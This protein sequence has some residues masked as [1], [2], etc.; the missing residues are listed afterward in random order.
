[1]GNYFKTKPKDKL[2]REMIEFL[3]SRKLSHINEAIDVVNTKFP[4]SKYLEYSDYCDV[5]NPILEIWTQNVFQLL[6]SNSSLEG[7]N[8]IYESLAVFTIFSDEEQELKLQFIFQ[9]FD[10]DKSG[11][12]EK[13]E[14]VVALEKCIRGLCKLVHLPAPSIKDIDFYAERLFLELDRDYSYTISFNEFKLWIIGNFELQDFLLKY[15]LIQ[16]Y[17]NVTRRYKEK[18]ILYEN[19]FI[20]AVGN[21]KHD[22]CEL[23][24]IK[25]LFLTEFNNQQLEILELLFKT[26]Q[27]SS[28]AYLDKKHDG[29]ICKQA[30][31]DVMNAWA[32]FDA[33]DI[34]QDNE[35]SMSELKYLIYAY[36][37]DKPDYYRLQ[38]EMEI[39][40]M[41]QSGKIT[42]DEWIKYLCVNEKGKF[43]FRGTLQHQFNEYDKDHDGMLS[44]KDIKDLLKNSMKDLRTSFKKLNSTLNF[45]DMVDDLIEDIAKSLQ[46][47]NQDQHSYQN[48]MLFLTWSQFKSFMERATLKQDQ[49]RQYLAKL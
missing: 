22:V 34:N 17:E 21:D 26:L 27:D 8:D 15:A 43:V 9:L 10:T 49:L 5:F 36:E 37:G 44:I 45:E 46:E 2:D 18:R 32:A 28:N 1:M 47:G 20:N 33:S 35:V 42:R 7:S 13:Q 29:W 23:E 30:Y 19:F 11:E 31:Q 24:L 16:T 48:Q 14:L 12:I 41:D 39:L 38:T 40:D 25:Q 4:Y 3:K 6:S